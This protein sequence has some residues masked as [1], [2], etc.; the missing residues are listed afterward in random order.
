MTT[1]FPAGRIQ[2][3]ELAPRPAA[4][5]LRVAS[6]IDLDPELHELVDVR[7]SQLNGCAFCIDMH[8]KDARARGMSEE[9]LYMLGAWRESPL[10]DEREQAALELCEAMTFISDGHVPDRVW[11]RV[12]GAFTETE[13]A[14]LVLAIAAINTWNRL[15]ITARA[16]PGHYQPGD[17]AAAA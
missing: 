5:L 1:S 14:Q 16:E 12:R 10:Y 15:Q 17:L 8:W 3:A 13:A 11:A 7:A 6:T 4:A 9:R 2:L